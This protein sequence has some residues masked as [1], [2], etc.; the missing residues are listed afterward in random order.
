MSRWWADA[1]WAA[2]HAALG[3]GAGLGLPVLD[4]VVLRLALPAP[5]ELPLLGR[6]G[7]ALVTGSGYGLVLVGLALVTLPLRSKGRLRAT[8]TV[9]SGAAIGALVALHVAC[10]AVHCLSGY[11]LT[12]GAL[13]FMLGGSE[14]LLRGTLRQYW[15]ELVALAALWLVTSLVVG[16]ALAGA[17]ARA[18]PSRV[19]ERRWL[20]PAL[21]ALAASAL[22]LSSTT[23]R[24]RGLFRS[25]PEL[26]LLTSLRRQAP[27]DASPSR[28]LDGPPRDAGLVW[29]RSVTAL[30]KTQ[31]ALAA[32]AGRGARGAR[33]PNVLFV[34]LEAVPAGGVGFLGYGRPVTPRLDGL[35]SRGLVMRRAWTTATH[36]NY[37]Q[38]AAL[39]SLFP[40][41]G[42]ALD[43]YHR[44]DYPRVLVH[45]AFAP[46]GYALGSISSQDETWQ[47]MLR[48]QETGAPVHRWNSNHYDGP[49]V[50]IVSEG[51]VPDA[52]TVERAIE[53]IERERKLGRPF[54]LY[55][56]LQL[57][58][59]PYALPAGEAPRFSP[60][61]VRGTF[62]Y[63][64]WS[65]PD[66]EAV[67]NRFDS[68]L[69]Y[70][71]TQVGRLEDH[72]R[73]VGELD[74]TI[75]VVTS[76]HGELFLEH[77]LVTHG[78]SLF[79]GEARVPLLL[80]YPRRLAPEV[81]DVPVSHLDV[82]PTVAELAG[83]PPHPAWQGASFAD[84]AAFAARRRAVF[85]N[86]QGLR[87]L[88]G[89]VC[90][91]HK[92]VRDPST[93][94]TTLFDLA[95][96]P[97]ETRPLEDEAASARLE[98]LVREH[99]GAQLRYHDGDLPDERARFA[100]RLAACP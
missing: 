11:P 44:L 93:G 45:D 64:T 36:S 35:A 21:A 3:L 31:G 70:V 96:D 26:A 37:A 60:T 23:A 15:L 39:S 62:N 18:A 57:T 2:R 79:E 100:P 73:A 38:M 32:Q 81:S 86:I 94:E 40:R 72:L 20:V 66:R 24:A 29:Q 10:L 68:A 61:H 75:L 49:R 7:G 69:A 50:D 88:E 14:H 48:F 52:V 76:D 56:N 80:H 87:T 54:A 98:A 83:L 53:W 91:P 99:V 16:R 9:V 59:F 1:D 51:V 12:R 58:H 65:E 90:W 17:A 63:L 89:V 74:D 97:G 5:P 67:R 28:A 8:A 84:R 34:M 6:L 27:P 41:R 30:K 42:T 22:F 19:L 95:V 77:G 46:L 33:E 82:L 92:L 47:G 43:M 71:D 4:H 78:R 55:V 25:T 13:E 85:L